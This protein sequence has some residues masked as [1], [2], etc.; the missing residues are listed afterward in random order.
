MKKNNDVEKLNVEVERLRKEVEE[1]KSLMRDLVQIV[2]NDDDSDQD[3]RG[4]FPNN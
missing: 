3:E 1:L 4:P 2:F